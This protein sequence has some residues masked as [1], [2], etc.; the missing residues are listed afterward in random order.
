M[1]WLRKSRKRQLGGGCA[2]RGCC[3]F[4]SQRSGG[5]SR[6]M[7]TLKVALGCTASVRPSWNYS[8][9]RR[10]ATYV[11]R[12][13]KPYV[14]APALRRKSSPESIDVDLLALPRRRKKASF[15]VLASQTSP[16]KTALGDQRKPLS[17]RMR[18][19]ETFCP[20]APGKVG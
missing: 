2:G 10:E 7:Q 19:R 13:Q 17:Q 9:K 1:P 16:E 20:C 6:G 12:E 4:A 5:Q 11:S 14:A 8:E 15:T 3:A 18:L